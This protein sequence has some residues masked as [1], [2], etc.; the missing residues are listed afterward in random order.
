MTRTTRY[1]SGVR[2]DRNVFAAITMRL[3]PRFQANIDRNSI[4]TESAVVEIGPGPPERRSR[5]SGRNRY[6]TVHAARNRAK[7]RLQKATNLT[8]TES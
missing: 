5:P 2:I 8:T 4:V 7:Q 1:P 3:N 6:E